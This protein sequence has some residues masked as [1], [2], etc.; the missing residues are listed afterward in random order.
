MVVTLALALNRDSR[1]CPRV[2]LSPCTSVNNG[3][4]PNLG[5]RI[6]TLN[7]ASDSP[8]LV[9]LTRLLKAK[10]CNLNQDLDASS[11]NGLHKKAFLLLSCSVPLPWTLLSARSQQQRRRSPS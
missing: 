10:Y 2:L 11:L 9:S 6:L 4:D 7:V 8:N 3:Q 5:C 1:V